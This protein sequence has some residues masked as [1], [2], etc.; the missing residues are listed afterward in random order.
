MTENA[1]AERHLT[2]SMS[3][4]LSVALN[5]AVQ[6]QYLRADKA[7][8]AQHES[9]QRRREVEQQLA[10]ER[11][12]AAVS[13]R[14]VDD[15]EWVATRPAEV[16]E[17]WASARAWESVD[18]RAAEARAKFDTLLGALYGETHPAVDVARETEDYTA[19]A[20]LLQR[21]VE[22]TPEQAANPR[23][24]EVVPEHERH[25]WL[26]RQVWGPEADPDTRVAA[27]AQL[28]DL[29][30]GLPVAV[31]REMDTQTRQA[32]IELGELDP[33]E[34]RAWRHAWLQRQVW[35]PDTAEHRRSESAAAL[36]E[37][38]SGG[39]ERL[40]P[41]A[42]HAW[43][44]EVRQRNQDRTATPP[45]TSPPVTTEQTAQRQ[46]DTTVTSPETTPTPAPRGR[47]AERGENEHERLARTAATVRQ[48]WPQEVAE[49]V[50]TREAFGAFAHRL[51]Q[52]EQ[53]GYAMRDLLGMIPTDHLVGTDRYGQ[54][55]R[56][57]AAF[58]EWHVKQLAT[59]LPEKAAAEAGIEQLERYVAAHTR[60]QTDGRDRDEGH[61]DIAHA[62]AEHDQAHAEREAADR[63]RD[64]ASEPDV[65]AHQRGPLEAA[66]DGHEQ[67]ASEHDGAAAGHEAVA[68]D[69]S[70]RGAY[71][72]GAEPARLAG[73]SHPRTLNESLKASQRAQSQRQGRT[74]AHLRRYR[75][76][77]PE[78][79]R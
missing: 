19:L 8:R 54:P 6:M 33:E 67:R 35:G 13:W 26:E 63:D 51:H 34:R 2:Q 29:E 10:A 53:R 56:D 44:A 15:R 71:A 24:Y 70:S 39:P 31:L 42:W 69:A 61:A 78:R 25:A 32:W 77:T 57:P 4:A 74:P 58:A 11:E 1:E 22:I 17:A 79:T 68:E 59:S 75:L 76:A 41:E 38:E 62:R 43:V 30:R 55:V 21:A 23:V 20:A 73:Q 47:T 37:L 52:L 36:A 7:R 3:A 48:V 66:A 16:A 28:A 65:P 12:T 60:Q 18:P 45:D 50:V 14:R 72:D 64:R 27:S 46:R 49:Q 5:I 9:E 40:E